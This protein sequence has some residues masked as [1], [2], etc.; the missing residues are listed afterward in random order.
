LKF[1]DNINNQYTQ[2]ATFGLQLNSPIEYVFNVDESGIIKIG[3]KGD[4]TLRISNI[5]MNNMQFLTMELKTS[6]DYEVLSSPLVYIGEVESD[7]YESVTYTIYAG[8]TDNFGNLNLRLV[9]KYKDD[10]NNEYM[11][12][13]EVPVEIYT[14]EEAKRYGLAENGGGIGWV[15]IL[16]IIIAVAGYLFYRRCKKKGMKGSK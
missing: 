16:L 9:L 5:G 8:D 6:D 3:Q 13:E 4:V 14:D 2:N 15:I 7:D 10:Y 12:E 11:I 1:K